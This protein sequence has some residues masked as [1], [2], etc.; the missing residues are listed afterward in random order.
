MRNSRGLTRDGPK[1]LMLEEVLLARMHEQG[2]L[3]SD[4]GY[5]P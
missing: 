2:Q 4:G 1:L 3:P 5:Y